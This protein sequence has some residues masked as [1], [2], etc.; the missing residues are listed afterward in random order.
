MKKAM[1]IVA[2]VGLVTLSAV[3]ATYPAW[4][5]NQ[6]GVVNILDCVITARAFGTTSGMPNWNPAADINADGVVNILDMIVIAGHFG[7]TYK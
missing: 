7:E 1:L 4:D 3:A 5:V 2:L 6:D